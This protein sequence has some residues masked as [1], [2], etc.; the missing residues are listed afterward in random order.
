MIKMVIYNQQMLD[1]IKDDLQNQFEKHKRLNISYEK[2][3]KERT[4]AQ[5]GFIFA[6]LLTSFFILLLAKCLSASL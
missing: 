6:A 5:V 1:R 3:H 4:M 2:A